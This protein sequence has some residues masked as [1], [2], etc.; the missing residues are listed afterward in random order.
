M[1]QYEYPKNTSPHSEQTTFTSKVGNDFAEKKC[2]TTDSQSERSE[3]TTGPYK[4]DQIKQFKERQEW[5]EH[6]NNSWQMR[7]SLCQEVQKLKTTTV[8]L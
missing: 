1:Q 5:M 3:R 2:K 8:A 6:I 7:C 4:V